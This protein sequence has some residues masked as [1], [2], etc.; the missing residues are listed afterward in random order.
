MSLWSTTVNSLQLKTFSTLF[1]TKEFPSIAKTRYVIGASFYEDG[2]MNAW[3]NGDPYHA[4][5]LSLG[6]LIDSIYKLNFGFDK[7]ISFTN[8]PLP[9]TVGAQV[10]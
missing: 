8:H 2:T 6:V 7:S 1:K 4:S 10:R 5:P 9:L 3:F